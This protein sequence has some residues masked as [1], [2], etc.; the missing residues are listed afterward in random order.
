MLS[1]EAFNSADTGLKVLEY[2]FHASFE[3]SEQKLYYD[4]RQSLGFSVWVLH[5]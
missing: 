5:S 2:V 1:F 4:K 3:V